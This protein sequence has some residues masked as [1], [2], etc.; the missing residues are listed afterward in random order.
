[1]SPERCLTRHCVGAG[2]HGIDGTYLRNETAGKTRVFCGDCGSFLEAAGEN[3]RAARA[4]EQAAR[5][6]GEALAFDRA[7]ALYAVAIRLGKYG[8]FEGRKLR[9]AMAEA[10][11]NAER[12]PEAAAAYLQAAEGADAAAAFDCR[13]RAAEHLL[14]SGHLEEGI[15]QINKVLAEFG[16]RVPPTQRRALLR[17]LWLRF[18]IWLRNGVVQLPKLGLLEKRIVGGVH[19]NLKARYAV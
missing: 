6:A 16:D 19:T 4:A 5:L 1:M 10:F 9:L 11:A 8:V 13:R 3:E 2:T 12:G 14:G 7:A 18:R 17:F 15:A